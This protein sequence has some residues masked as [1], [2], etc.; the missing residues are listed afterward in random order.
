MAPNPKYIISYRPVRRSGLERILDMSKLD[1][2]FYMLLIIAGTSISVVALMWVLFQ[3][4]A[5][6][7]R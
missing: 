5:I 7:G 3:V 6:W 1:L 4:Q 2:V